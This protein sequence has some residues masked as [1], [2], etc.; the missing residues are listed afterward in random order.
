MMMMKK[1]KKRKICL[2]EL[3]PLSDSP[4]R[5]ASEAHYKRVEPL[6]DVSTAK[7]LA[8]CAHVKLLQ[9]KPPQAK[10]TLRSLS[11]CDTRWHPHCSSVPTRCPFQPGHKQS[12]HVAASFCGK[13]R[14][15]GTLD[16]N[17]QAG[18]QT[19]RPIRLFWVSIHSA[20]S[21]SCYSSFGL[22]LSNDSCCSHWG[23]RVQQPRLHEL[24]STSRQLALGLTL[25][26]HPLLNCLVWLDKLTQEDKYWRKKK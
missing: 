3:I 15:W 20:F 21:S 11:C 17:R 24:M 9:W 14:Q 2:F 26:H 7:P 10:L 8:R 1:K 18:N 19:W 4:W 23:S 12:A 5:Q 13:E 16:E 6:S 22:I 25:A